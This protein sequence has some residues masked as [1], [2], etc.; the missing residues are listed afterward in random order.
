MDQKSHYSGSQTFK[1]KGRKIGGS[2]ERMG[3]LN[4]RFGGGEV[5]GNV[6]EMARSRDDHGNMWLREGEGKGQFMGDEEN[7]G[8]GG[9]GDWINQLCG[10]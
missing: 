7:K 5:I 8:L 3:S 4:L 9:Q 1:K 10:D 2:G 6:K